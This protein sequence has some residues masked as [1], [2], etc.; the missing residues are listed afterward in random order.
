MALH[1]AQ[2]IFVPSS[3]TANTG[4]DHWEPLLRARAIE[5]GVYIVAPDQIGQKTAMNAYGHSM[6]IDPW[7]NITAC[8]K[9]EP[10]SIL[11][12][13][14]LNKVRKIRKQI[15]SLENRRCDIHSWKW[16]ATIISHFPDDVPGCVPADHHT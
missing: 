6:I 8:A 5:N 4:K 3:F 11:A 13:I 15:P 16:L 7:G 2:I 12:E 10:C 9:D 1:G 14:D